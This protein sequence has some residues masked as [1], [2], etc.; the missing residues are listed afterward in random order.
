VIVT[1]LPEKVTKFCDTVV[2]FSPE[3]VNKTGVAVTLLSEENIFVCTQTRQITTTFFNS[4]SH[5][6]IKVSSRVFP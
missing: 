5:V 1:S 3:E 2:T 4:L 6:L